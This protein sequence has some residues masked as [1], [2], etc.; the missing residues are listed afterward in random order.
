MSDRNIAACYV[1]PR[2][3]RQVAPESARK[4]EWVSRLWPLNRALVDIGWGARLLVTLAVVVLSVL[5]ARAPS[6][7]IFPVDDSYITI[8]NAVALL[9]GRDR[10]FDSS[11]LHGAT[12]P[13]HTGLVALLAVVLTPDWASY[14]AGWLA[15]LLYAL[16]VLELAR[17]FRVDALRGLLLVACA[18][19]AGR[20][21]HQLTNGLETGLALAGVAWVLALET[22]EDAHQ[23]RLVPALL[24][25]LP[26]LRPEL[27][28]FSGLILLRRGVIHLRKPE[29]ERHRCIAR[30][31]SAF[32]LAAL[33]VMMWLFVV[34]GELV[35][36]SVQ[37]KK[38]FFA[39]GC[40]ST[41][42]RQTLVK[43]LVGVFAGDL[44]WA[45]WLLPLCFLSTLGLLCCASFVTF[46]FAY[47]QNFPG[48]LS[49]YDGRYFYI[50]VPMLVFGL[51]TAMASRFRV[52]QAATV[53]FAMA[54]LFDAHTHYKERNWNREGGRWFTEH[55]L[56]S[57]AAW[58][59]ANVQ[60][61]ELVLI[62]DAGYISAKTD[63]KLADVVG[64]KTPHSAQV[65][66]A[67][68]WPSCGAERWR[69]IHEIATHE[70]PSYL[71]VLDAW[72]QLYGF[73]PG[74][75]LHGWRVERAKP[76]GAY[77]IYRLTPPPPKP[78]S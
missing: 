15:T 24:G 45:A 2:K 53:L 74:L 17:S 73:V 30:D 5:A 39:E 8:H 64:L 75:R 67:I 58:V 50:F 16:G 3:V 46:L 51:A 6:E 21:A 57:A 27:L 56:E 26:F 66:E 20:L 68:T 11:A 65:H 22:R 44:G 47:Y 12:S 76:D 62:H 72:D 71:I 43:N 42:Y 35:P 61:L 18:L 37:A 60:P 70:K 69:A 13:L 4:R 34:T 32:V 33:P 7:P 28:A 14:A 48:A 59:R 36:P 23:R 40:G 52:A 10:N 54:L 19:S 25:W 77:G 63:A 49:H 38:M 29:D 9:S 55:E 31:A 78:R 41:E 1:S